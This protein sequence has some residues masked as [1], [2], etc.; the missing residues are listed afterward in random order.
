MEHWSP[1]KFSWY[2]YAMM[3]SSA[4]QSGGFGH[5]SLRRMEWAD[6]NCDADVHY[7]KA[8]FPQDMEFG[9]G[10]VALERQS[11]KHKPTQAGV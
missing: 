8:S 7:E 9:R 11:D 10:F 5:V 3:P 1:N 6:A 2:D 4:M